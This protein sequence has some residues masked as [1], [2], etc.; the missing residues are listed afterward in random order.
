MWND[1][2][3]WIR[4]AVFGVFIGIVII[5]LLY[6]SFAKPLQGQPPDPGRAGGPG[7]EAVGGLQDLKKF[8]E[9]IRRQAVRAAAGRRPEPAAER[10]EA[11]EQEPELQPEP[12]REPVARVEAP[13]PLA[14]RA[15][16]TYSQDSE[17]PAEVVRTAQEPGARP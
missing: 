11:L 14:R 16:L 7:R 17:P 6:R 10:E 3:T 15:L 2:E 1:R 13:P 9:D 4:I 12:E 5:R 8:L